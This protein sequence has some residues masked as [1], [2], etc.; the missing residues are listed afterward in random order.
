MSFE[1]D[2]ARLDAIARALESDRLSLD[3]ALTL[4]EEGIARLRSAGAALESAEGKV[5]QLVEGADGKL[6]V[7]NAPQ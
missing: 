2:L 1:D 6:S 4:F 3:D 5:K 7:R